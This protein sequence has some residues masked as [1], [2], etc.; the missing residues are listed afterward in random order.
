[1]FS[2]IENSVHHS[3]WATPFLSPPSPASRE[4][5]RYV[6]R[7]VISAKSMK[8]VKLKM[9]KNL[10][11]NQCSLLTDKVQFTRHTFRG[12]LT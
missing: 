4:G 7:Q 10:I 6:E 5:R 3:D 9:V 2:Q 11:Y 1:M 12:G 8:I